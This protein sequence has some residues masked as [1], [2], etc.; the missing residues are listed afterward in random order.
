VKEIGFPNGYYHEVYSDKKVEFKGDMPYDT[1]FIDATI[2]NMVPKDKKF[3]SFWTTISS[4]GPYNSNAN[5]I[6]KYTEAGYYD[7]LNQ[8]KE[9]GLWVNPIDR[10]MPKYENLL[11]KEEEK[12]ELA[13]QFE[14]YQVEIMNFDDALGKLIE[15]LK[16]NGQYDN[17]LFVIYGDHDAY[18]QSNKLRPI[19]YYSYGCMDKEEYPMQYEALMILSNHKLKNLYVSKN[20]TNTVGIMSSPYI[21]VPTVLDLLGI[22]YDERY[23]VNKSLFNS[24]SI[25]NIFYSYELKSTFSDQLFDI[26]Y[27][28]T[29]YKASGVTSEYAKAFYKQEIKLIK[30]IDIINKMYRFKYFG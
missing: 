10:A 22:D 12:K 26:D 4:H 25:D 16:Q 28:M 23:Y 2:D 8:A 3:Y 6:K 20:S 29:T 18:Y 24:S 5:S 27:K 1:T 11:I 9:A 30:K 7:K 21:I 17:T 15:R 13:M 19:K 14:H